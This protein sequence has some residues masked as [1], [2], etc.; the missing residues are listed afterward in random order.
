MNNALIIAQNGAECYKA[1]FGDTEMTARFL[2]G[3]CSEDGVLV[4]YDKDRRVC[5][6]FSSVYVLTIMCRKEAEA[7]DLLVGKVSVDKNRG[8]QILSFTIAA[9]RKQE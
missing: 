3:D 6:E 1:A 2:E 9:R 5:E 8:D 7:K 4:Y